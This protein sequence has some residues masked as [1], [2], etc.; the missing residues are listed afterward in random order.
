[1]KSLHIGELQTWSWILTQTTR[2]GGS[3]M[4]TVLCWGGGMSTVPND[5]EC[6]IQAPWLSEFA[7]VCLQNVTF[8]FGK[9]LLELLVWRSFILVTPTAKFIPIWYLRRAEITKSHTLIMK[10][11]DQQSWVV[12]RDLTQSIYTFLA[13]LPGRHKEPGRTATYSGKKRKRCQASGPTFLN[14]L[15]QCFFWQ[16][17]WSLTIMQFFLNQTSEKGINSGQ[18]FPMT[19]GDCY[20]SP[21]PILKEHLHKQNLEKH[22]LSLVADNPD[23]KIS[24]TA[25]T[26]PREVNHGR[27]NH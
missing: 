10:N 18:R 1:M 16:H 7:C 2:G 19:L 12:Q 26:S 3:E 13:Q 27:N 22:K 23:I 9:Q 25:W 21:A 24:Y 15:H 5:D 14:L 6:T 8:Y 17:T 20:Q 4:E 11:W